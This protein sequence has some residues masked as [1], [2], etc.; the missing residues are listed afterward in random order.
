M[1]F[2][3][4]YYLQIIFLF[5]FLIFF[6]SCQRSTEPETLTQTQ[7]PT[8]TPELAKKVTN[9][10]IDGTLRLTGEVYNDDI[11]LLENKKVQLV[12]QGGRT[13]YYDGSYHVWEGTL[14]NPK[15]PDAY[16]GAYIAK[17]QYKDVNGNPQ[18]N[19]AGAV[20]MKSYGDV[21]AAFGFVNPNPKHG[22]RTE[23]NISGVWTKLRVTPVFNGSGFYDRNWTGIYNGKEANFHNRFDIKVNNLEFYSRHT[24]LRLVGTI[25]ITKKPYKANVV[26]NGTKY[27]SVKVYEN[28]KLIN[29][30]KYQIPDVKKLTFGGLIIP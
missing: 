8:I 21:W 4:V 28:G 29:S 1:R 24:N 26:C 22:D 20:S 2:K 14:T 17:I 13:H 6:N 10:I 7:T 18:K 16:K 30:Y 11:Q 3:K 25:S 15:Y 12:T 9:S 5:T 23:H 27:A 19:A